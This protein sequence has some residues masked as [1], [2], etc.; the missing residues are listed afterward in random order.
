VREHDRARDL[1]ARR[2]QQNALLDSILGP[3]KLCRTH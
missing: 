1:Q 3:D 2:Q